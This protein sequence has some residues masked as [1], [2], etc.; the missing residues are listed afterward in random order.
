MTA[1]LSLG[2]FGPALALYA[3]PG[4]GPAPAVAV[5]HGGEGP[6]AGW[7]HRFA[8]ILAAHGFLALALEYGEGD[9]FG[10]GPIRAV[11]LPPLAATLAAL[12]GHPRARGLALFG[13]SKGAEAAA[14]LAA[15]AAD[16]LPLA[17][18]ALHAPP[19]VVTPAFDPAAFRTGGA[20]PAPDPGA[21]PAWAWPGREAAL[22]P[23][24]PLP[25]EAVRAPVFL[26]S[27]TADPVFPHAMTL[28][29]A[30]R[31]AEAGRPADLFAA[32]GQGHGYDWATEPV[33]WA[34]LTAFLR[35]HLGGA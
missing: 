1:G 32:E 15:L 11:P 17:A 18:L 8:A 2:P 16:E 26:S 35:R 24:T 10:A 31:L 28:A 13:W 4:S 33:L 29:L 12:A 5:L 7:S 34:R 20:L 3:P 14:L 27:G 23:G 22:R 19:D 21:P 30:R 9:V 6:G 25:V